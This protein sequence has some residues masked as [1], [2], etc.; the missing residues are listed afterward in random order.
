MIA[1]DKGMVGMVLPGHIVKNE[2]GLDY[3]R[4]VTE[5][6][7]GSSQTECVETKLRKKKDS[8]NT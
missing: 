8:K 7:S 2:I 4:K 3:D 5:H 6:R 1:V